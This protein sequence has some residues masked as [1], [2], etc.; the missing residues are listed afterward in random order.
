MHSRTFLRNSTAALALLFAPVTR[1]Q[2]APGAYGTIPTGHC[3]LSLDVVDA[4]TVWAVSADM[5]TMWNGLPV[6]PTHQ[7][8]VLRTTDG[9]QTWDVLQPAELTGLVPFTLEAV[10]ALEVHITACPTVQSITPAALFSTYDGGLTW[11]ER[12]QAQVGN[13]AGIFFVHFNANEQFAYGWD[14]GAYTTDGGATWTSSPVPP[15]ELF[16][17]EFIIYS[18]TN[19]TIARQQDELWIPTS[20]GRLFHSTDKGHTWSASTTP[21]HPQRGITTLAFHDPLHG[22]AMSCYT[23]T[24]AQ[25]SAQIAVTSDGGASWTVR[26]GPP[27]SVSSLVAVPGVP[28]AYIGVVESDVSVVGSYATLDDG[29]TWQTLDQGNPYNGVKFL[30]AE[31][32]WA[33]LGMASPD[34][35]G[36]ALFKWNGGQVGIA[37]ATAPDP[38]TLFPNPASGPAVWM[39]PPA[40]TN[41]TLH[42]QLFDALGREVPRNS[43]LSVVTGL[44]ELD[45]VGL[46]RGIY[47]VVMRADGRRHLGRLVVD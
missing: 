44:V 34:I 23:S 9:G 43:T 6:P 28:G 18:S 36:P 45:I 15:L 35:N 14:N 27:G 31:T 33:G 10:S 11:V 19:N 13:S 3:I 1:A 38:L 12:T 37:S 24:F 39:L 4:S 16:N 17:N 29:L 26:P 20:R 22:M 5:N 30:D 32:G 21:F 7:P 46:P 41:G 8:H 2:W 42:V 47:S 25:T 40:R